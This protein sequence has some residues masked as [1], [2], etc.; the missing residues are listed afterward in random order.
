VTPGAEGIVRNINVRATEIETF[1]GSSIIIPNQTLITNPVRNWTLR[2]T[3]G[4]FSVN[5][6]FVHGVDTAQV[7]STLEKLASSHPK[8]MR[9]PPPKVV[10]SK[11]APN[12][13]Q[14]DLSGQ[15]ADVLEAASVASDL[16]LAIVGSF[17]KKL[18]ECAENTIQHEQQ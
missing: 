10:L 4:R 9:H 11:I 5:V 14:F 17:D 3:M 2:D 8:V 12:G 1:D 18:L 13:L 7:V 6:G 16:R 15:V